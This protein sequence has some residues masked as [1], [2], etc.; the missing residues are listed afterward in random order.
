MQAIARGILAV[1]PREHKHTMGLALL[2]A[3]VNGETDTN[4][5]ELNQTELFVAK[6]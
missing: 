4:G 5:C 2:G 1:V 6:S 3:H